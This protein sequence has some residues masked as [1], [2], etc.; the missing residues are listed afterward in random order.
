[1]QF[2]TLTQRR[3]G[4]AEE[5]YAKLA[6]QE[7]QRARELYADGSIRQIWHRVDKPGACILWEADDAEQV[8]K[9]WATLPFAQAGMIE[10]MLIALKPYGGFRPSM[11]PET[12]K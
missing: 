2:L 8:R 9:L 1:M 6:D 4:F 10:L 11:P 7:V 3:D 12:R 5:A